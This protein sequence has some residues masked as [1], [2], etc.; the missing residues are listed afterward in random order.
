MTGGKYSMEYGVYLES[1]IVD[2]KPRVLDFL[3]KIVEKAKEVKDYAISFKKKELADLTGKDIRTTARYLKELEDRN[4]ITT[5]GVRGR[6][7]GTVIMFNTELIRFDTSDKAFINSDNPVSIDDIVEQKLPKKV[8]EPKE[9]SRNRR[10]KKQMFED[11]ILKDMRKSEQDDH[12]DKLAA[13][14]GIPNW[15]WFQGTNDP[16]GNYRTYLITRLYN[17]YSVLFTDKHNAEVSYGLVEGNPVP[18]VSSDYDVLPNNFYGSLRWQQFNKFREFCEENGIDP[19]VYLSAQ[20]NRSI[21]D[22]SS[23]KNKKM[24]PFT[25][26]LIS[27]SSYEVFKQYCG[28]QKEWS[29]TYKSY[30]QIPAKFTEDF[31]VR[32]LRESYESADTGIGLLQYRYA[33]ED[34]LTGVGFGDEEEALLNF[35]DLTAKNLREQCVS[36]KTRDSIKKFVLLQSMIQ[37]SGGSGLPSYV[38]LGSEMTQIVLAS[39]SQQVMDGK[40]AREI[41]ERAL[42]ALVYPTAGREEQKKKG[43]AL[44]YQMTALHETYKVLQLIMERKGLAL[45]LSDLNAAFKEYGKEKIPVDDFS[46]L[47]T[48]KVIAFMEQGQKVEQPEINHEDLVTKRTWQL[49]SSIVKDDNLENALN[50]Y[51]NS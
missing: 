13:L 26:A 12:N 28:F 36:F 37:T 49:E 15:E 27:D 38:I 23:K 6:A 32:A 25:N 16:I 4:V 22:S 3:T 29:G 24:L 7:G 30:Q 40:Q 34:F 21:F 35:Y 41:K 46:M 10:T 51:L 45:S 20:F 44:Y 47:D 42:G 17:R 33:I 39:I 14:G 43:E 9:K 2:L 1:S 31:V 11:K 18:T 19:A 50:D 8:K 5:R 48:G